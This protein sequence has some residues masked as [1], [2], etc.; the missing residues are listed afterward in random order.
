MDTLS[1]VLSLLN[2]RSAFSASLRTGGDWAIAF[3]PV[4]GIKF[5]ALIEGTCWLAVEGMPQA[6][7]LRAGDCFLLTGKRSFVLASDLSMPTVD[8]REVFADAI[9]GMAR[10]GDTPDLYMI[11]GS[12]SFDPS[13]ASMLLDGLP[14]VIHID[15]ASTQAATLRWVLD[16]LTA[17]LSG[18]LPGAPLMT[19]HLSHIM[20]V[21]VLRSFLASEARPATGWL[22][23]LGDR[24]IG[25]AIQLMHEAPARRWTLNDLAGAIGISR[26]SFALRFKTMVGTAP[27]DYLLQWRMRLARH[28]LRHDTA[29]V[30]SIALS[31]GYTSESA[32]SS[33]FKR[34]TGRAP[35]HYR[36]EEGA[37][38]ADS[39]SS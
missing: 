39:T 10:H 1:N 3:Q 6:I 7:A 12:F 17:E 16:N 27:L 5:N 35:L 18:T 19:E 30:S 15:G 32:F 38:A 11:G 31:L 13:D 20:L 14:P 22:A 9:D 24:R 2:V 29:S 34:V 36:R 25:Q 21:Q 4:Q 33:T 8:A 26:S 23:A 28:A 37:A